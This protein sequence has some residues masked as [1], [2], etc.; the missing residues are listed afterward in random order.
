MPRLGGGRPR[1]GHG[2]EA[3]AVAPAHRKGRRSNRAHS[4]QH[5]DEPI[6]RSHEKR[7]QHD[8]LTTTRNRATTGKMMALGL[9]M[10]VLMA[11]SLLAASQARAST[12]FTVNSTEDHSDAVL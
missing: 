4:K 7:G 5:H 2:A 12:T 1:K 3:R 9:L 8:M 11:A 6:D 10:A